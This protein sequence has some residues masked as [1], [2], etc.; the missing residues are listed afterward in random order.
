MRKQPNALYLCMPGG[1]LRAIRGGFL[2]H[3]TRLI[4]RLRARTALGDSPPVSR[5]SW[6][7]PLRRRPPCRSARGGWARASY[8]PR[9]PPSGQRSV[10]DEGSPDSQPGGHPQVSGR[11]ES[12]KTANRHRASRPRATRCQGCRAPSGYP[13][14]KPSCARYL[15]GMVVPS[16]RLQPPAGVR[17]A[18]ARRPTQP[19]G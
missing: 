6:A 9:G 14:P 12:D 10:Q 7:H 1:H 18:R 19:P 2:R 17:R 15:R 8:T 13:R 16:L 5:T 11:C 3:R 4:A